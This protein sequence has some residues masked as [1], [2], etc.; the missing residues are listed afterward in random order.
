[1][2][3]EGEPVFFGLILIFVVMIFLGILGS[4][5]YFGPM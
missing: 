3:A 1:M 5:G 2:L 4:F